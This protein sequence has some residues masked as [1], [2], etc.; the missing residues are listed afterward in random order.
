MNI[1]YA[2]S[3]MGHCL[4]ILVDLT[5]LFGIN[6]LKYYYLLNMELNEPVMLSREN[7]LLLGMVILLESGCICFCRGLEIFVEEEIEEDKT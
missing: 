2:F 5:N 7:D 4:M 1:L 6:R 3:C